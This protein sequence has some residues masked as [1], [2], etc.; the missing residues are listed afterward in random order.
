MDADKLKKNKKGLII[1]GIIAILVIVFIIYEA[2]KAKMA[3]VAAANK[4][5]HN[6]II[7]QKQIIPITVRSKQHSNA[8]NLNLLKSIQSKINKRNAKLQ[9]AYNREKQLN[10]KLKNQPKGIIG[11]SLHNNNNIYTN[12]SNSIKLPSLN[13]SMVV[14]NVSGKGIIGNVIGANKPQQAQNTNNNIT[15]T[16]NTNTNNN[17][18]STNSNVSNIIPLGTLAYA[19]LETRIYSLNSAVP[20]KAII[21]API[22]SRENKIIIPANS[23]IVGT[24]STSHTNN[25]VNVQFNDVIFPN[26]STFKVNILAVGSNGASGIAGYAHEHYPMKILEGIG[27]TL[28]GVGALVIGSNGITSNSPYSMQSQVRTNVASG[29]INNAQNSLNKAQSAT[30]SNILITVNAGKVFK[31]I[32]I[33]PFKN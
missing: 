15:S 8:S 10:N 1:F 26:G 9:Q 14:T 3:Q 2:H 22:R 13:G 32:F 11:A 4:S 7:K 17:I 24:A 12:A 6:T 33:S 19:R 5:K 31:I 23:E 25:R 20:V 18:T 30:S 27:Q 16:Q 21:S 28:L 29:E